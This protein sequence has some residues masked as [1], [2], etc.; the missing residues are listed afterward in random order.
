[1]PLV[2]VGGWGNPCM[3]PVD[4][5]VAGGHP[6]N[7]LVFSPLFLVFPFFFFF[8]FLSFFFFFYFLAVSSCGGTSIHVELFY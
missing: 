3:L 2:G 5:V 8:F 4:V 1:M 7:P 6:T